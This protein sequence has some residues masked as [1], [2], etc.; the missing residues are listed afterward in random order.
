MFKAPVA[1]FRF[2]RHEFAVDGTI[3]GGFIS[4]CSIALVGSFQQ[5]LL[6]IFQQLLLKIL[7]SYEGTVSTFFGKPVYSF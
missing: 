1:E 5:L 6:T 4:A 7:A 2:Y 3:G